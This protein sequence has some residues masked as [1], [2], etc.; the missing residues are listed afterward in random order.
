M[1]NAIQAQIS[2]INV[3]SDLIASSL[4]KTASSVDKKKLLNEY[5]HRRYPC[6]AVVSFLEKLHGVR[7]QVRM[8]KQKLKNRLEN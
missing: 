1:G 2:A 3:V 8:L 6:A 5:F 7:M 4:S